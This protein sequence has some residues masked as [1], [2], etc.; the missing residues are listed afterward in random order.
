MQNVKRKIKNNNNNLL[1][2]I[3]QN[4][5][6]SQM[7][8]EEQSEECRLSSINPSTVKIGKIHTKNGRGLRCVKN[9]S[10]LVILLCYINLLLL[11]FLGCP[12]T[13]SVLIFF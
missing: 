11:F 4:M 6:I 1:R 12:T 5:L 10:T 8:D 7:K 3:A 9:T 13:Y 2:N